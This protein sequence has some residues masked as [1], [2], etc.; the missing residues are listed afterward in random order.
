MN[1][2]EGKRVHISSRYNRYTKKKENKEIT[3]CMYIDRKTA[4]SHIVIHD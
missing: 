4:G 1:V 3:R 2:K